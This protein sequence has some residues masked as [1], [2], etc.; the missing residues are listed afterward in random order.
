MFGV[1]YFVQNSRYTGNHVLIESFSKKEGAEEYVRLKEKESIHFTVKE[2]IPFDKEVKPV[3][4]VTFERT[5]NEDKKLTDEKIDFKQSNSVDIVSKK[6][7]KVEYRRSTQFSWKVR[8]N[9]I[10]DS[11][12]MTI[13]PKTITYTFVTDEEN[14]LSNFNEVRK[15]CDEYLELACTYDSSVTDDEVERR[16]NGETPRLNFFE[17]LTDTNSLEYKKMVEKAKAC[18]DK[19]SE[20]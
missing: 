7:P 12:C 16:L 13:H 19:K 10:D 1:F 4:L 14:K 11:K 15:K 5:Y 3:L 6:Y 20:G 2:L 9:G 8:E 17:K 18:L